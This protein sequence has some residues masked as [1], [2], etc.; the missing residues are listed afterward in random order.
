MTEAF[1]QAVDSL[2][3]LANAMEAMDDDEVN[4]MAYLICDL[5]SHVSDDNKTN[6]WQAQVSVARLQ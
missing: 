2:N 3:E 4:I 1:M 6:I 5:A